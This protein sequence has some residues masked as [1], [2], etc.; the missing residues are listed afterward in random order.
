MFYEISLVLLITVSQV[1]SGNVLMDTNNIN[2]FKLKFWKNTQ[3]ILLSENRFVIDGA[4]NFCIVNFQRERLKGFHF[5]GYV[6]FYKSK[7]GL[8]EVFFG[9]TGGFLTEI[10]ECP[11]FVPAKR[12]TF[13]GFQEY[14]IEDAIVES[15]RFEHYE[16]WDGRQFLKLIEHREKF[17]SYAMK[18]KLMCD[19]NIKRIDFKSHP[20]PI[21]NFD[22]S[23]DCRKVEKLG[24]VNSENFWY[25]SAFHLIH[26][27]QFK[28]EN[29]RRNNFVAGSERRV[30]NVE[31]LY[32]NEER[33]LSSKIYPHVPPDQQVS[34]H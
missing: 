14:D 21:P 13:I 33:F 17:Y 29:Q 11:H 5:E 22:M 31:F 26:N 1:S 18:D 10:V 2:G 34:C 30:I 25:E 9:F 6:S 16:Y 8:G 32:G 7:C 15:R 28:R 12:W 24:A 20:Y 19:V 27:E 3:E 4:E 23:S